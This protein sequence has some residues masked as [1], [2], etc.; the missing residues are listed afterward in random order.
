MARSETIE[1]YT[2]IA[3]ALYRK[4]R[5]EL[6]RRDESPV[7]EERVPA[8]SRLAGRLGNNGQQS[9]SPSRSSD[10]TPPVSPR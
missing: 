6:L 4:E 9:P 5:R 1:N 2:L 10:S 8:R 3:H 7:R